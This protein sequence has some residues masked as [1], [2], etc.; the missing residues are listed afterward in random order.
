MAFENI[1]SL[2][3]WKEVELLLVQ[4]VTASRVAQYI[5][6]KG[7]MLDIQ[8]T[9][10]VRQL[11]RWKTDEGAANSAALALSPSWM[12]TVTER[13]ETNVDI[14]QEYID[15]ILLQRIRCQKGYEFEAKMPVL[16]DQLSKELDRYVDYLK[17]YG[18]FLNKTRIGGFFPGGAGTPEGLYEQLS[19]TMEP[20]EIIDMI[21]SIDD[22]SDS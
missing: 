3:C 22:D 18:E 13:L 1:K 15:V 8:E 20:D 11:N 9:S 14:A 16:Y 17:E 4:G 5:H 19:K 10:I 7:E 6:E 12:R 21:E 2:K